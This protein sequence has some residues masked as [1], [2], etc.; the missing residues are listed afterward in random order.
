MVKKKEGAEVEQEVSLVAQATKELTKETKDPLV[1]RALLATSFKGFKDEN[2]VKQAILEAMINGYTFQDIVQKKVYAIPFGGGYSL[3][4]AISSV[5]SIA[6]RSG[7]VGKSAP[8]FTESKEG[9]VETC[10]ITVQRSAG[11]YVGDYTATVYFNEYYKAGYKGKPSNWDTKPRT[12]IAKVA[13]MHALRS[14]FP[15]ELNQSYIEDEFE[16]PNKHVE[17]NNLKNLVELDGKVAD[18]LAKFD[19]M[20]SDEEAVKL[21]TSLDKELK[22]NE[23][24]INKCSLTRQKLNENN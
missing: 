4:Q 24:V 3:V 15:E 23:E 13:E 16:L 9:K 14:A 6:M 11:G 2:L 18:V 10:T 22:A 21:W 1:M 7:Q 20:T 8:T 17:G 12:M 19:E 5:R